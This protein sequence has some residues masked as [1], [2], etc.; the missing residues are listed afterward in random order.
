MHIVLTRYKNMYL[1]VIITT[2]IDQLERRRPHEEPTDEQAHKHRLCVHVPLFG[3]LTFQGTCS[4]RS[5]L[6]RGG[7]GTWRRR[8]A[9][10]V[11]NSPS[12]MLG[13]AEGMEVAG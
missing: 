1:N 5:D 13:P 10:K 12:L 6:S 7:W 11:N 8:M 2:C 9:V 4:M 3:D